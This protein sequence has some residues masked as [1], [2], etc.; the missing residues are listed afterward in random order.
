MLEE[1]RKPQLPPFVMHT[2]Q[3]AERLEHPAGEQQGLF[4][5][6]AG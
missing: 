6:E 2:F 3:Q 5:K 1:G 4:G